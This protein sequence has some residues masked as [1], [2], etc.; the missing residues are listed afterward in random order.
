MYVYEPGSILSLIIEK[1]Y[2]HLKI[3]VK[4]VLHYR[5]NKTI[6]RYAPIL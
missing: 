6:L 1:T 3:S 5:S 4:Q 2:K